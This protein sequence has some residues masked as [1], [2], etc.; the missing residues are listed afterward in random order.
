MSLIIDGT[1][2][3][4]NPG[5]PRRYRVFLDKQ[6][7]RLTRN[8]FRTLTV[9][10]AARGEWVE[11]ES[12]CPACVQSPNRCSQDLY[13]LKEEIP[14]PIINRTKRGYYSIPKELGKTVAINA[15]NLLEFP[16]H[17]IQEIGR[18]LLNQE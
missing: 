5:T 10:A 1:V 3:Q 14:V 2:V 7:Y 11:R 15:H 12:I 4:E 16:D 13:R 6:E 18:C 8:S 17:S 9:L